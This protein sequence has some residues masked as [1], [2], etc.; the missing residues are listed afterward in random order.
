MSCHLWIIRH[1]KSSWADPGQADFDRDLNA[2]GLRD[3][4]RMAAQLARLSHPPGW[5]FTSTA[6]RARRTSEFVQR[7]F[8]IAA[9][10]VWAF[11]H[12]YHASAEAV[13]AQVRETPAG[14]SSVALVAHNPGLTEF[15]NRLAPEPWLPNLPT[16]GIAHF[17]VPGYPSL[18]FG[19]G[20]LVELLT[21]KSLPDGPPG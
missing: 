16:F 15:V 14:C 8:D 9:D 13:L 2:R 18:S 20:T 10:R 3:G 1:A 5:L 6:Q 21:P 7:G 17:E 4:E 11:D 19:T 12:L